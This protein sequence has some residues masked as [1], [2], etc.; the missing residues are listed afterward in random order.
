MVASA[1]LLFLEQ[2]QGG[3]RAAHLL[4]RD[5]VADWRGEPTVRGSR[6]SHISTAAALGLSLCKLSLTP[7][8]PAAGTLH[9]SAPAVLYLVQNNLLYLATS[10]LEAAVCQVGQ[11]SSA[12]P[13]YKLHPPLPV[14]LS[15][16]DLHAST[17]PDSSPYAAFLFARRSHTSSSSSRQLCSQSSSSAA[18]SPPADGSPSPSSS[19]ESPSSS[20][21]PWKVPPPPVFPQPTN[22]PQ[23]AK[24]PIPPPPP[25]LPPR[26][27]S[28][29]GHRRSA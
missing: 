4:W 3:E 5:I 12:D 11:T 13:D 15:S 6:G 16:T 8:P 20:G 17:A 1:A 10:N 19:Q 27:P 24:P 26:Q 14:L 29:P 22:P 21:Q 25:S 23:A 28:P 18:P 2:L 9:I 7:A